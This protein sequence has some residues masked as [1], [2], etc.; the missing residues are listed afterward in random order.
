MSAN[1][2]AFTIVLGAFVLIIGA[3]GLLKN[4]RDILDAAQD[5]SSLFDGAVRM[6]AAAPFWAV[7]LVVVGLANVLIRFIGPWLQQQIMQKR[8]AE[9]ADRRLVPAF[10]RDVS[11]AEAI[12]YLCFGAWGRKFYDAAASPDVSGNWEY[13]QFHQAAADGDVPV[14]G[15]VS[16]ADVYEPIANEFWLSNKIEWFALLK[17]NGETVPD[18]ARD[19]KEKRYIQLMTS[20][21][22]TELMFL[23]QP[24][25]VLRA[26]STARKL[27]NLMDEGTRERNKLLPPLQDF[28][29]ASYEAILVAWDQRVLAAADK[30]N[31]SEGTLSRFRTLDTFEPELAGDPRRGEQQKH[32]ESIW[33][34]KLQ[35]L[36]TMIDEVGEWR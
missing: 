17:G 28:D 27:S 22:A 20:R 14:W 29:R 34:K 26:K 36:R 19:L 23:K 10:S 32:L 6:F 24:K 5:A 13:K 30:T 2:Y 7:A 11:V 33:N 8:G 1:R 31:V 16:R 25:E 4:Y 21:R 18:N 35:I 12:A 9:A 15:R 3:F